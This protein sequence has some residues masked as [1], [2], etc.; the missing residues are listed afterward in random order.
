MKNYWLAQRTT[1]LEAE[2]KKRHVE[3]AQ[4]IREE[5]K[6]A[7][8]EN[9]NEVAA[10]K[11]AGRLKHLG[12]EQLFYPLAEEVV[13]YFGKVS[14]HERDDA[15]QECVLIAF[16]KLHRFDP[17]KCKAKNFFTTLMLSILRMIYRKTA[18]YV[19]LKSKY[20][21]HLRKCCSDKA[22]RQAAGKVIAADVERLRIET[23]RREA[24][25][26]NLNKA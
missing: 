8:L 26:K 17:E 7:L 14:S 1:R 2:T 20:Q 5:H 15:I 6:N 4:K 9:F 19:E 22:Q 12:W 18:N 13:N 3:E 21:E 23:I 25:R 11:V 16:E 10:D 24:V